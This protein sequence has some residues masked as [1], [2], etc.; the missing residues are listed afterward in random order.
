MSLRSPVKKIFLLVSPAIQLF[1]EYSSIIMS[2]CF[3]FKTRLHGKFLNVL[4]IWKVTVLATLY[5]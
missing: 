3:C 5:I 2:V 1:L 4:C